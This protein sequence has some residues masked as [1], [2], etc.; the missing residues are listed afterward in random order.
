LTP[1]VWLQLGLVTVLAATVQGTIGFA[2][3]LLALPLFLLVLESTEAI[4]ILLVLNL[5]VPLCLVRHLW[6]DAPT[7]L[8]RLLIMGAVLGLP[9]GM[10]MFAYASLDTVKVV[11]G[12]LVLAFAGVLALRPS[13]LPAEPS[14]STP[15]PPTGSAVPSEDASNPCSANSQTP[16]Y[17]KPSVL[18]V[19]V[20]AGAMTSALSMPGPV[21]ALYM[22]GIGLS[23]TAFRAL[24][25]SLSVFLYSAALVLQAA[26][27]GVPPR[28]WI[29]VATLVPLAWVGGLAGHALAGR[30]GETTFLRLVLLLLLA[31]GL[32]TLITILNA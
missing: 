17:R 5:V 3:T 31:T 21:L 24:S 25:L 19:G 18:L 9:L 7:D 23:K 11:V 1:F 29:T 16:R 32:Y 13:S 26:T 30:I 12:A 14:T 8:A 4:Q 22:T 2:F 27:V 10:V 20:A 15:E 6:R 28:V